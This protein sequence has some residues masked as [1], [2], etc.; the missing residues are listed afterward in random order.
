MTPRA[1][2]ATHQ[3]PK[4]QWDRMVAT[5]DALDKRMTALELRSRLTLRIISAGVA[6]IIAL[7][8]LDSSLARELLQALK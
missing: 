3:L 1:P 7:L 6:V 5:V 2:I 4:E 8:G